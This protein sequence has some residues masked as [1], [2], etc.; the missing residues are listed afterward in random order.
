MEEAKSI[1]LSLTALGKCINALA[2]GSAHVPIRDSKLTRLLRDSFGG[3]ILQFMEINV[4]IIVKLFCRYVIITYVL[5][6]FS[7]ES[8]T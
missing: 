3:Y 4:T 8:E 7:L 6:L 5:F 1:N 2:E